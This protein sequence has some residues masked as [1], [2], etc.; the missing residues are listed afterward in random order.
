MEEVRKNGLFYNCVI[1]FIISC[2]CIF[3]QPAFA[4]ENETSSNITYNAITYD[5]THYI[6][7]EGYIHNLTDEI[8]CL[9][10]ITVDM[11]DI[12]SATCI[13]D[14]ELRKCACYDMYLPAFEK[15][16]TLFGIEYIMD[17]AKKVKIQEYEQKLNQSN[18]EIKEL[19]KKLG[20]MYFVITFSIFCGVFAYMW[21]LVLFFWIVK[22]FPNWRW[23]LGD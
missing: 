22:I 13:Y 3:Q 9:N 12:G 23:R 6:K 11:G 8:W 2:I 7:I 21:V 18:I 17:S 4:V 10:K 16:S 1:F 19:D 15:P 5:Q 14:E 20:F